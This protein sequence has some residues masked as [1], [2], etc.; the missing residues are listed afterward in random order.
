MND[1]GPSSYRRRAIDSLLDEYLP[2]LPAIALEGPKGVGKT[3]TALQRASSV[4]RLDE[5]ATAALVA[6]DP[7]MVSGGQT[8]LLLDEW[9]RYPPAWDVVRRAVDDGAPGGSFL[10]TGSA[11][12][13]VDAAL[14]SGAGRIDSLRMR[15]FS[16]QER[17]DST[18]L[19][20]VAN[21]LSGETPELRSTTV[22]ISV[23][24]Y[25]TEICRS[26]F[27]GIFNLPPRLR[28]VRIDGYINRI[29]THEF[30]EQGLRV[31]N[32]EAVQR[33]MAGYA[34]ATART[35][36]YQQIRD[37]S[38]PGD[39]DKPARK[40]AD[41]Y[42]SLLTQLM[43]L[44]PLPAWLPLEP[45]LGKLIQSP[46]HHL[47]DPALAARLLGAS[48]ASLVNGTESGAQL[49]AQFF[50]SL[51]TLSVRVAAE[52][53]GAR[54]LHLRTL[55]GEHEIDIIAEGSDGQVVAIEVKV[56]PDV[57]DDDVRHLA[58]LRNVLGTRFAA[59]IV[60]HAGT[61]A[62]RRADGIYVLPLAAL[63]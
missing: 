37:Y 9:Q 21:L 22:P 20:S 23:D 16:L 5:P 34:R 6:A 46:K 48:P 45:G 27:P 58:W 63:G 52:S 32:P 44:E 18:P 24:D 4:L 59:G 15:P 3:L 11:F 60:V 10:L 57:R 54:A 47:C 17:L 50:E 7:R 51:C 8:P 62:Y 42:R 61:A 55:R 43:I 28:T 12:P 30:P 33:W 49:F 13:P 39:A 26:G 35:D 14:H 1:E 29:V 40:T 38:T 56:S 2:H 19:I 31:R 53:C 36:S 25:A 41:N